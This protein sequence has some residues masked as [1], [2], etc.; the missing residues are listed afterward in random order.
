MSRSPDRRLTADTALP[1]AFPGETFTRRRLMTATAHGAAAVAGAAIV[2]PAAGFALGPVFEREK[3]SWQRVGSLAA[4]PR[5]TYVPRT[6]TIAPGIGEA[7]RS[8]AF[9]RRRD[10]AIDT[11]A[12]D[13]FNEVIALTSRCAHVGCPVN[14]VD[15]AR[16]FVCPCHG[17]VYAFRGIRIAGPPPRPLD[18]FYTR[19][20]AGQ[21]ELGPRYSVDKELRRFSPRDPGE[22]LDG[23]GRFLYPSRFTTPEGPA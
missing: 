20:T 18:R 7:G 19:V 14:Y 16:S 13:R 10:P 11:E 1:G 21:V 3:A 23:I 5:A 17:G 12:G 15:A 22:P 8:I 2:L 4:L 6:I 9:L